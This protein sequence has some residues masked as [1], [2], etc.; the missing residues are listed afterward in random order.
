MP[1]SVKN[2]S[3]S[4]GK[5]S[6]FFVKALDSVT[7]DVSDG[8]FVGIIGSTGS[9][10][11]TLIQHLNGL[12]K[13][14]EGT[15]SVDEIDLSKKKPDLQSLRK[16]IGMLF[17]YPEYQLFAET[18]LDDVLFGPINFG[19]EKELAKEQARK[20]IEQ[21][22]LDFDVI[23]DRSPIE[24]SGGQKRRVAIAGVLAYNPDFLILDEPTAGLDP[25]GKKEMLDLV[26]SLKNSGAVKTVIMVSHNLDEIAEYADRLLVLS[27]GKLLF[28]TTCEDFF[29]NEDV[30][31]YSLDYPHVV[32]VVKKLRE[33][34]INI[35]KNVLT[36]DELL[37]E[38]K[39][40][41]TGGA[42]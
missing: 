25:V 20:A 33:K 15:I 37:I 40:I 39:G 8:E 3:F 18:V 17:Q 34:G 27:K 42:K 11:S 14:S 32:S 22:G 2:L 26:T 16:K 4:Y 10:K 35:E 41:L 21:V 19:M 5:K 7:F 13:L 23:K 28:D 31:S 6:A 1:I 30:T 12:I 24:L 9:G 36:K 38:L 29:Y